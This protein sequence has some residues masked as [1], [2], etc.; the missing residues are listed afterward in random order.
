MRIAIAAG[1]LEQPIWNW[2]KSQGLV[3][4]SRH[5]RALVY[6]ARPGLE[7]AVVRG[8]D[9]P[10]LLRRGVVDVGILG[11]DIVEESPYELWMGPT[12]GFGQCRLMLALPNEAEGVPDSCLRVATR[13]P[14][15]TRAWAERE[16][17]DVDIV[18][19]TGSV[20]VAP[21]LGI[22][23]AVVDVVETGETLRANG[24]KPVATVL[25]SYAGLVT[26]PKEQA[27]A[28]NLTASEEE[29]GRAACEA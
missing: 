3:N 16:G 25:E 4:G 29:M 1:R 14:R 21:R 26:R 2:L 19:M 27:L 20:E 13:Y 24:L 8:R 10:G 15:I 23:D 9:I 6:T 17:L 28:E 11:R 7:I 12:L 18:E 22:A 5:G